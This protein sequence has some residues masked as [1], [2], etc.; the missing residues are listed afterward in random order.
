MHNRS[1]M[2]SLRVH[3]FW[4][5]PSLYCYVT[6]APYTH[7]F[8]FV[9][10]PA[11]LLPIPIQCSFVLPFLQNKQSMLSLC[12]HASLR[13]PRFL[14]ALMHSLFRFPA[15]LLHIPLQRF[16]FTFPLTLTTIH[17]VISFIGALIAIEVSDG[18]RKEHF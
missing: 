1:L 3:A 15:F 6:L 13:W 4:L 9:R 16:G 7:C 11:F 5:Y 10:F 12:V 14:S 18:G 2:L 17:F 8:S